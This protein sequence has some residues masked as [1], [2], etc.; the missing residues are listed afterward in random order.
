[1]WVPSALHAAPSGMPFSFASTTSR[2]RPCVLTAQRPGALSRISDGP[3]RRSCDTN[4]ISSSF[5]DQ[6]GIAPSRVLA[7]RSAARQRDVPDGRDAAIAIGR[8]RDPRSVMRP[9][10][11]AIVE[12]AVRHRFGV[13]AVTVDD[14]DVP[15]AVV[16]ALEGDRLAVGG[17][18][19]QTRFEKL[20]RDALR[21]ATARGQ[22]PEAAEEIDRDRPSIRRHRGRH[23]RAFGQRQGDLAGGGHVLRGDRGRRGEDS[24]NTT[25]NAEPA[26]HA[27]LFLSD[28]F[29]GA[30]G[31]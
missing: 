11:L 19:R 16:V 14:V 21:L 28:R 7:R 6:V 18:G 27:E 8:E 13:A 26:E 23:R 20:G 22:H 4:A 25:I 10:R 29:V 30:L 1:M 15:G 31:F 17:P 12:L 3:L 9:R 2:S 5:G 24:E